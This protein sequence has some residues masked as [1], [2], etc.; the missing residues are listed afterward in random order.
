MVKVQPPQ[1]LLGTR[2]SAPFNALLRS[3]PSVDRKNVY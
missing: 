1:F 3:Y 2:I